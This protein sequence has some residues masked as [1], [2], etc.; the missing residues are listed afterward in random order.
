MPVLQSN[1]DALGSINR[2]CGEPKK[3]ERMNVRLFVAHLLVL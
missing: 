1:G 3:I 2:A